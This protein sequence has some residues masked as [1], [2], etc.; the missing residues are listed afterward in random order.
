MR[1]VKVALINTAPGEIIKTGRQLSNADHIYPPLGI[2]YISSVLKREN[3]KV[4]IIDQAGIGYNLEQINNWIKKKDPDIIGFSTLT[5]SGSG[6]NAAM[7]SKVIRKWNPN[8]KIIFGNRHATVNDY[9]ILEKYPEVDVCVLN[10]GEITFLELVEAYEKNLSLKNIKGI[11]YRNNGKIIRN[12]KRKIIQDLDEIPFPDRKSLNIEYTG[13]YANIEFA[14]EGFT[15][16]VSS[17]GCPYKCSFCYGSRGEGF[18]TRSVEN[19]LEEILYLESEGYS[20]INFVDDNFTLSQKRVIKLCQLMRKNKIDIDWI[21]E[22]RVNQ[23]SDQMLNE[24]Q[25]ANCRIM[26]FGVESANQRILNYYNKGIT[27]E[28]SLKA[29]KKAHKAKIPIILGSFIVGAPGET[30]EEIYNTLKFAQKLGVDFPLFN[31]LGTMPGNDIWDELVAKGYLD[32]DKYW[33]IGVHVPDIDPNGVP[34]EIISNMILE[35]LKRF[36]GNLSYLSKFLIRT[37][38]IPYRLRNTL[39]IVSKNIKNFQDFHGVRSFW[40]PDNL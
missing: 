13:S 11:T 7:I 40:N 37:I 29:V 31:L 3:Y 34:T 35:M 22:G 8:V 36:F 19:I 25:R 17:R 6:K 28:Q 38:S 32:A 18:R 4:D 33:E 24:M 23:V 20:F 1:K 2:C 39:K 12:E 30:Y 9:R 16:I 26:C 5:N 14:P 10:E 21:C 15:S 27:P